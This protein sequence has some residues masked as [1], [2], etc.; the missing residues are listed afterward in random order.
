M[1]KSTTE[2]N[3]MSVTLYA[4]GDYNAGILNPFTINI[5]TVNYNEE[6][7][8]AVAKGLYDCA[9]DNGENNVMSSRCTDCG[10]VVLSKELTECPNCGSTHI[11]TK[12]TNEEY[13]LSDYEGIPKQ[14]LGEWGTIDDDFWKYKELI[15]QGYSNKEIIDAGLWLEI[16]L[17]R[18]G[19]AYAGTYKN[20]EDFAY[21][22]AID[23]GD[24]DDSKLVPWP[25]NC[26]DWKQAAYQLMFDY[27]EHD[28]HYFS[29]YF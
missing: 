27:S 14:Y 10:H 1:N 18:I 4:L 19:E 7:L 22:M 12:P 26:I 2:Q 16:P 5:N 15:N 23:V 13:I 6:Y 9:I 3:E 25:Y 21:Q 24:F 17:D 29:N 8:Q 28:G 11:E 20:D